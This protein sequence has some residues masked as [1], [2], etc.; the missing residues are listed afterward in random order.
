V[1]AGQVMVKSLCKQLF[2]LSDLMSQ[3]IAT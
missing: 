3:T 2:Y 1:N